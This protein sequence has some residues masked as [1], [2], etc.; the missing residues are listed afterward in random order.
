[1]YTEKV[2]FLRLNLERKKHTPVFS[3]LSSDTVCLNVHSDMKQPSYCELSDFQYANIYNLILYA[4]NV[5]CDA[6]EVVKDCL[7]AIPDQII[8]L[9][10]SLCYL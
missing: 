10:V 9:R 7:L 5:H 2:L 6:T 1:M 3:R 8:F 4:N